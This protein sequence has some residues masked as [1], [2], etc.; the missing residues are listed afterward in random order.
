M[1]FI[2]D[3]ADPGFAV[4]MQVTGEHEE[5]LQDALDYL[6]DRLLGEIP[7]VL[8]DLVAEVSRVVWEGYARDGIAVQ[9]VGDAVAPLGAPSEPSAE[10]LAEEAA[11][12]AAYEAWI[13]SPEGRAEDERAEQLWQFREAHAAETAEL[14]RSWVESR[15][16]L[17]RRARLAWHRSRQATLEEQFAADDSTEG[18]AS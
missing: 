12:V 15:A 11:A 3:T 17:F 7:P 8:T 16:A 5:A 18:N 6:R 9:I 13:T 2:K 14:Y 10:D 1:T 4:T